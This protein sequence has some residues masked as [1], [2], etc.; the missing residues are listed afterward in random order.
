[1]KKAII[2]FFSFALLFTASQASASMLWNGANNDCPSINVANYTAN[3]G[4]NSPCWS[5]SSVQANPGDTINVR[6]YYHNSSDLFGSGQL[7]TNVRIAL[8]APTGSSTMHSFSGQIISNEGSISFGPVSVN[9]PSSQTLSYG[10]TRWYPNQTQSQASFLNG[11]SGAE[12]LGGGLNIGNIPAGWASQG[13]VVVSFLVGSNVVP[14][15]CQD[16]HATNFGGPLPCTYPSNFCTILNYSA[17]PTYVTAGQPTVLSWQTVNCNSLSI[18]GIGSV[19]PVSGGST[20][21]YPASTTVYTLSAYGSNN[22]NPTV[23]TRDANVTVVPIATPTCPDPHAL[24]FGGPLPCTYPVVIH[25][26]Q[27]WSALNFGGPLPCTYPVVQKCQDPTATNYG[28]ILPCRY[29]IVIRTCQD[30]N[31]TNFGGPLPCTYPANIQNCVINNFNPSS[32]YINNGQ[33]LTI[34]WNTTNCTSVSVTGPGINNSNQDGSQTIYPT[35]SGTYVINAYGPNNSAPAQSFFVNVNNNNYNYNYNNN[36]NNYNYNYNSGYCYITSFTANG[37]STA[38]VAPNSNVTLAWNTSNCTSVT[39]SGPNFTNY[40]LSGSQYIYPL[41]SG[42]YTITAYGNNNGSQMQTV[43]VYVNGNSGA[44]SYINYV[45]SCAVTTVA[46]NITRTSAQVN[47]LI[48]GGSSASNVY[49]EYGPTVELGSRTDS[50]YP[51]SGYFSTTLSGLSSDSI[52][53]YRAV[54]DCGGS[55]SRGKIEIFSTLAPTVVRPTIVQG[56]TIAGVSSPVMLKIEDKYQA[57]S[58]GDTIDYT[59]TYKNISK[60]TLLRP[61]LQIVIPKG[62]ILTKASAGSYEVASNT[63]NIPLI[64]LAPGVDGVIYLQGRVDDIPA[65]TAQ[66]VTTAILVYTTADNAQQNAMAYVL[67]TP[68]DLAVVAPSE[69]NNLGASAFFAGVFS[70]GLIGWLL[71]IIVILLL[72]LALRKY[73]HKPIVHNVP[74]PPV[75]PYDIH[76][77]HH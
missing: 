12:V 73:Y 69:N 53:Y 7:A 14:Q 24:N 33:A 1:M 21:V 11:Q 31:A 17:S 44:P 30:W 19:N 8:N 42:T 41:M 47:G 15:T 66:I 52:Y 38:T 46:T 39:V 77:S 54:A 28:G 48:N 71:I 64:D 16:S 18:S 6:L 26:C 5:L 27:D 75:S 56:K 67:N 32:T 13:S 9:L 25:K 49:F 34:N 70:I 22:N 45:N 20:T 60:S 50:Q 37:S 43:Q 55:I 29:P 35:S 40:N 65:S 59:V 72:I 23:I 58:V 62:I 2:A 3:V 63:Q 68:R 4:F 57:I 51:G 36:Y 61:L 74:L 10:S 76:S